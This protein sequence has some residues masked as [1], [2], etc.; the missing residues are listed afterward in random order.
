[1]GIIDI[2]IILLILFGGL[3]GFK[4]GVIK[5]TTSFLG[6][7]VVVIISFILKNYLSSF[8]YEYLPFFNFGGII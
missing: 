2:I 5:K 1:M 4:E 3:I 7:F 6:L 8:F